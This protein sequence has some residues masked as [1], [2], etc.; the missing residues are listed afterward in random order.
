ME[1]VE[2]S[3]PGN[4]TAVMTDL[5]ARRPATTADCFPPHAKSRFLRF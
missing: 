3:Y 4:G 2:W 1:P 5:L